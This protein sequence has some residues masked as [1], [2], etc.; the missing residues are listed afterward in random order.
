M[1]RRLVSLLTLVVLVTLT[2]AAPLHARGTEPRTYLPAGSVD[3]ADLVPPPPAVG[4]AAFQDEMGVVL[5][6]QR[7]RT[8]AQVA[9]V[10]KSLDVERFAPI[11]GALLFQV[12]GLELK[13]TI[14]AVIDEAR[15]EYDAIKAE[16]DLPRPF[17]VSDAVRPVGDARPVASYPSGH[18]TRAI[19]YARLLA[20]IFPERRDA[21]RELARQVGYGR[22]I[23]GVHYPMD[24]LTG[25]RL[26]HAMADVV[27]RQPA[28]QDAVKRIRRTA[29][30]SRPDEGG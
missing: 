14:D 3:V 28:F 11:L 22:V 30:P 24:V 7:T 8:P 12:D 21:L 15:A 2:L 17:V 9:F 18:A 10:G 27:I 16:Y 13:R 20:E 25:Q 29:P 6:L 1:T 26:G 5:W 4:S 19:I 23:A